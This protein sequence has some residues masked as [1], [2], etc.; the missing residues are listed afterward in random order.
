MSAK[1]ED[2]IV[3]SFQNSLLRSSDVNLLRGPYWLN[4]QIIS[5]YMEYLEK[6]VYKDNESLLFVSPE[7][8]QCIKLVSK[9]EMGIFLSPLNATEKPFVFFPLN[10]NDEDRAGGNHWSLLVF[11]RPEKTFFHYD[12]FHSNNFRHCYNFVRSLAY[13]IGCT[14]FD[15]K[16]GDCLQQTNGYDC[17]IHVICNVESIARQVAQWGQVEYDEDNSVQN[18]SGPISITT[19]IIRRKRNELLNIIEDLNDTRRAL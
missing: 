10:D 2:S 14:E 18:E 4:D 16:S 11:S 1:H 3:L 13:G 19:T 9:E 17:G 12:S 6:V 8:V 7:V 5:F 15:F